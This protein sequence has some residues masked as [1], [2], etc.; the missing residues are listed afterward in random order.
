MAAIEGRPAYRP[1]D[2]LKLYVYGYMNQMRSSRRLERESER[3]LEVQWLINRPSPSFKTIADF[4][5]DHSGAIVG[6]CGAFV[7]F[8]RVQRLV[9][10]A[11]VAVDGSKMEAVASRKKVITPK[12]LEKR[13]AALDARIGDYLRAMD[14]ADREAQGED[15]GPG[16][17]AGALEALRKQR[18][19]V[20]AQAQALAD[21][22]LRQKVTSEPDARLMKTARH[23]SSGRL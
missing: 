23:W 12:K 18:E 19:E 15:E 5:K 4:R 21:E 6:V 7:H 16:H 3:N 1:G 8:C 22:G 11:M 20:R 10:G 14:A 9:A 17:V 13:G 2:L